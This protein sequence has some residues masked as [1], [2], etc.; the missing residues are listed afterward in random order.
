MRGNACAVRL[1]PGDT[2]G[3][4]N[5]PGPAF[6]VAIEE[7]WI[8]LV[9]ERLSRETVHAWADPLVRGDDRFDDVPSMTALQYLHGFD[10]VH[11][12]GEVFGVRHGAP[13]DYVRSLDEVGQELERWRQMC[14]DYD[15]DP[16]DWLR[17]ARQ[18]GSAALQAIK[19]GRR[20]FD[21]SG[22]DPSSAP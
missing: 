22:R 15:C 3:V 4:T 14:A 18:R 1:P 10:L 9:E 13:G 16:A 19:E 2:G 11:A 8:A 7:K 17:R 5:D 21:G 20:Q 6:R 12:P